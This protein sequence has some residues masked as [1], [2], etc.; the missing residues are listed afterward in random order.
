MNVSIRAVTFES[1]WL[2][3]ALQQFMAYA[4]CLCCEVVK[5]SP[6]IRVGDNF[7]TPS[8]MQM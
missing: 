5:L 2:E 4:V 1:L 6:F 7:T 3:K 8:G